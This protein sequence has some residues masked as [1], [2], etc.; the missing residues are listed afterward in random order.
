MADRSIKLRQLRKILRSFECW[1][2]RSRGK[3]S[4]TMFFWKFGDSTFS[5]PV[6][7]RDDVLV[8]YIKKIR[9]QFRLTED[10]GVDDNDFYSRA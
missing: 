10:D 5:V 2:V 7:K 3:G 9:R 4:H 8:C 6:P 1:E